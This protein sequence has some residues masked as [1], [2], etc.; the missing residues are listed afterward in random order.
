MKS[1]PA[2][3]TSGSAESTVDATSD[4]IVSSVKAQAPALESKDESSK[5]N[6]ATNEEKS[7]VVPNKTVD[8]VSK[9]PDDTKEKDKDLK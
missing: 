7:S 8:V 9:K 5:T 2:N 1:K 6:L 3:T 4:G